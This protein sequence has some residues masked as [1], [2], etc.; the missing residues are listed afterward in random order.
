MPEIPTFTLPLKKFLT[1]ADL[2]TY[3]YFISASPVK[4]YT[5]RP[6]HMRSC[7]ELE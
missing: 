1:Q 7:Q 4:G 3:T 2:L 6:Q 5:L